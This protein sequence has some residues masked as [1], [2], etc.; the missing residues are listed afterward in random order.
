[1][2]E[3]RDHDPREALD[4]G[5]DGLDAFRHLARGLKRWLRP[6]GI[7]A[8][9]IGADQADEVLGAFAPHTQDARAL[10]DR[11]GRPRFVIGTLRGR[12]A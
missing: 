7:V 10:P 5:P 1:M 4:G 11:A 2:A 3:V 12:G 6:G 8:L 9:E